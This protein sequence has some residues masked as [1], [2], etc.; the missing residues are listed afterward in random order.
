MCFHL[1]KMIHV[2][3]G[4]GVDLAQHYT[5]YTHIDASRAAHQYITFPVFMSLL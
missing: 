5:M 3:G 1:K 2:G 4:S